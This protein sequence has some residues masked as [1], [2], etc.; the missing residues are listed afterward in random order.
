MVTRDDGEPVEVRRD[1]NDEPIQFVWHDRL[2]LVRGVLA[3]WVESP[4]WWSSPTTS[5][6]PADIGEREFWRVHAVA[7][8]SETEGIYELCFDW[9]AGRWSVRRADPEEGAT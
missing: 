5:G 7:G 3:H 2:Y 6:M 8:T 9:S 1:E 4:P